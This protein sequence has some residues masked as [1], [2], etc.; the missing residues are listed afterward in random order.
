[1]N[2]GPIKLVNTEE[3]S[4]RWMWI[5]LNFPIRAIYLP[6]QYIASI[7]YPE[8][9]TYLMN[10][11]RFRRET[12][13][14]DQPQFVVERGQNQGE[15]VNYTVSFDRTTGLGTRPGYVLGLDLIGIYE[16]LM[17]PRTL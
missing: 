1:V 14:F 3:L 10:D 16:L 13:I 8:M 5:D 12:I 9:R 2:L 15:P 7:D 4:L 17:L 11:F 6:L